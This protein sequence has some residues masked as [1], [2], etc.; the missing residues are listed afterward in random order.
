MSSAIISSAVVIGRSR[1]SGDYDYQTISV[2]RKQVLT[3][4]NKQRNYLRGSA[5]DWLP[6]I[7]PTLRGIRDRCGKPDWDGQGETA[8][9]DEVIAISEEVLVTLFP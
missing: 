2:S 9:S 7:R 1:L 6:T 8:V 5:S 3:E 4:W